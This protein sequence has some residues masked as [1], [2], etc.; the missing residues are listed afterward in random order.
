MRIFRWMLAA[1]LLSVLAA[2]ALVYLGDAHDVPIGRFADTH[3]SLLFVAVPL[4]VLFVIPGH[5]AVDGGNLGHV[6]MV[7]GAAVVEVA[8]V[9]AIAKP[10]GRALRPRQARSSG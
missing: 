4:A 7:V 8:I 1:Y 9:Y 2:C 3:E 5:V 6:L 10:A